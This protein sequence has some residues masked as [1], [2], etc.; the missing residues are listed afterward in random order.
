M[1]ETKTKCKCCGINFLYGE[2]KLTIQGFGKTHIECYKDKLLENYTEEYVNDRINELI[3]ME[4]EKKE[5]RKI[6]NTNRLKESNELKEKEKQSK[7]MFVEY[8]KNIYDMTITGY[9]YIKLANINSGKYKGLKEGISY[10]D[11]FYM[12]KSKYNELTKIYQN[13]IAKGFNFKSNADR[14]NYD[15]AIIIN[16]YDSYKRWKEKQKIIQSEVE[17]QLNKDKEELKIDYSKIS[18]NNKKENNNTYDIAD[19]LDDLY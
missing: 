1:K 5:N 17:I 18:N 14:F 7:E 10:D 3:N 16:K 11:L 19:I 8:I 2:D 9:M 4:K 6:K 15:L 13:N 12:F